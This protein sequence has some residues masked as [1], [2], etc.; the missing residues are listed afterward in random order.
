MSE[1]IRRNLIDV[2][3]FC[4]LLSALLFL[5]CLSLVLTPLLTAQ[6][7]LPFRAWVIL[8]CVVYMPCPAV[9]CTRSLKPLRLL[10]HRVPCGA[11]LASVSAWFG[12]VTRCL[13]VGNRPFGLVGFEHEQSE[14]HHKHST[15]FERVRLCFA[16]QSKIE[17]DLNEQRVCG[18]TLAQQEMAVGCW[19]GTD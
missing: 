11:W 14:M 4:I 19:K 9:P 5:A 15:W 12:F 8:S 7:D 17:E 6:L 18:R 2:S 1:Y 16:S 10:G 3:F 13:P